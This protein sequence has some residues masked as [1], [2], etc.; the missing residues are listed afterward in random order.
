MR[1]SDWCSDVCS[2]DRLAWDRWPDGWPALA[3][4]V[5][6]S[7][8]CFGSMRMFLDRAPEFA[9]WKLSQD[10]V[11]EKHNGSGFAATASAASTRQPPTG[12]AVAGP[13]TGNRP[14]RERE[15]QCG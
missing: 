1:I 15:C 8:W 2:S 10:Y 7:M 12:T 6:S 14:C 9:D 4:K 11:W 13:Q 3:A 5:A